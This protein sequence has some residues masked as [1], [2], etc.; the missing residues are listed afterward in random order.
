MCGIA[1]IFHQQ[2][3]K[4]IDPQLLVNMAAIQYHRGPDGFGYKIMDDRG[5]GF[6]HARLSIIDLNENRARQPFLSA[7]KNL[8]LAHNGEFYDY[9]R[10]RADLTSR[11]ARF[12]TKSDSE[13][14]LHLYPH[15]GLEEMLPH[16][17]GEFAFALYDKKR[18]R[19]ILVRDRFGV[20][21]LYWTQTRD[22]I[23]FGSELKVLFAHP[24]VTRQFNPQGLYHQLMQ[25]IVPG[26]TAFDGIHQIKPGHCLI[27]E[28]RHG[29]FHLRD[30]KFWDMDF[31]LAGERPDK[32]A[33]EEY[34][35]G[36]REQ[37][38][39]A[40][41]LRLEAD[42]PVACYLSGGID[43][44]SILGLSAASQQ[45][46]V[47]AF[48]IGFDDAAYDETAIAKEMA[49]ATQ[50]D[51]DILM[52][53]ADHLYD[54]FVQTLWHTER[55]IYNTLGVAK[56]LMSKH[57]KD[58]GY[59]V[60]VTGEG[61]DELFAGY[62]AFRRDM[63]LHG[64]DSLSATE[65]VGWEQMLAENN[66]LFKGAMLAEEAIDDPA[67]TQRV[68]F[69]PSCLQPWLASAQHAPGLMHPDLRAAVA[70][71]QPGR[72]I[73]EQL[74]AEMLKDR[75]PLDRAQYVWIK[76][77][78]EGQI[79][80]WGGDRV[81]MANSMEARPA[82]LDH[83]LAEYACT[84]P[85][86]MRIK[87]RTEKYVLREAMKG[88]LPTVLYEREKFAFMAPPAHTDPKKWAA[89]KVLADQY[90]SQ[91]AITRAGLLDH[92]GVQ[93]LFSQ[94]E[95]GDTPASTQVQMDAVIN[96]LLGVQILHEHFIASDTP[97]L[98]RDRA[99]SLG[100]TINRN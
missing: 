77:M 23:V 58:A 62:P 68:G 17:R 100:W 36:V 27:I 73:A 88:L 53:Q 39:Q 69:T 32:Y 71:Y 72:A 5:V 42:V 83:H 61:S 80:T 41:Q 22:A 11:G 91:E 99:N 47:K 10:L 50:A 94:H 25:T 26:T 74:D 76:T 98:A 96:H 52:L 66:K 46:A 16:L 60:V 63:F 20:K 24:E 43:S 84:I 9:K 92:V 81:D 67:L 30:E 86:S 49:Q 97:R 90:L 45:S 13:L 85:P 18:D 4:P 29:Q 70:D 89:M 31:P 7:D 2:H 14:V 12:Q 38:M 48:T 55:T 15:L 78:L 64:L 35:E 51:Q 8:L 65:R 6:S 37:L 56:F 33:E 79:L 34:I 40:V 87:G 1:G 19:L 75:H 54:N 44:C 82:F 28:R 93:A 57:V 95:S 21:P 59:K 3:D